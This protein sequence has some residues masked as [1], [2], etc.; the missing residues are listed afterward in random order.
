VNVVGPIATTA[1][2]HTGLGNDSL[3]QLLVRANTTVVT[4]IE[5]WCSE[6]PVYEDDSNLYELWFVCYAY[7]F[8]YQVGRAEAYQGFLLPPGCEPWHGCEA[9][10]VT[11]PVDKDRIRFEATKHTSWV[12]ARAALSLL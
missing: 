4:K 2:L 10:P 3:R 12:V 5:P 6:Q 1:R 9:T 8:D 11:P 7:N